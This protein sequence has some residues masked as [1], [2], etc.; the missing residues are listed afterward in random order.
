MPSVSDFRTKFPE[1]GSRPADPTIQSHID[2]AAL[3]IDSTVWG[4]LSEKAIMYLAAHTLAL[5]PSARDMRLTKESPETI[6]YLE[7]KRLLK[8]A[9]GGPWVAGDTSGVTAT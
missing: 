1:F 2:D 7:Y 4:D 5:S 3:E 8:T 6:Y 9:V